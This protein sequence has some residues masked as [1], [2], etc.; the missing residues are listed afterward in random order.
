MHAES[1]GGKEQARVGSVAAFACRWTPAGLK[2]KGAGSVLSKAR[3]T[4]GIP[5]ATIKRVSRAASS[6]AATNGTGPADGSAPEMFSSARGGQQPDAGP[7]ARPASRRALKNWRV[8]SRLF[9]LVIIPTV[10]AVAAGG[11]FIATSV[12]SAL[13]LQRVQTLANLSGKITGLVQALQTE[14][15]DTVRFIVLGG[16]DGGRGALP[17]S[18]PPPGPELSLLA[19][20][21]GISTGWADQVKS[22]AGGVDGSYSAL[23]QQDTQAAVTAIGNLPAIRA[24]ATGTQLPALIVI[25]E[26]ATTI[27]TLLAVESQIAVGSGD[28]ALAGSVRVLGLVSGMKEDASEQ[29]ALL[30]SALSNDLVSLNQVQ[31]GPT[32][33]LAIT[34]AQAQQ[35]GGL[36]EFGTA[37]TA[38]QRQLFNS[39]LSSGN[40]V[41]AQAEEQ[42]AISLASSKSPIATDPT[43]SDASSALSYVVSGMRSVEQQFSDSVISRSASL[44]DGSITSA[45]IFSLAVALLLGIALTATTVVGRSMVRPLRRL[46]NGALEVAEVRLPD[47]VRRMS[48]TD[49]EGVALKVEPIDV[50]SSDE[51]GEVARAFDQVHKEAVRLASNEAA[52]RGNINAMFVNLSRRSQVLVERQIRVITR[53]ER[54]EQDS[55]RL[56]NLFQV[57]HL[58]TRMRRNSEN[59]LVLAGQE[60]SR[61]WSRPVALVDVLRA[62]VSEIEQY[63]RVTLNV[64]PGISVGREAVSDVVHLTAELVENATSFSAADTPVTI[65]AHLLSSGGAL[66]EITDQGVGM[67]PEEMPHANWR[68][69]NPPVVDVAVSRRMGLFVVGRLA[70]RHGIRVRLRPAQSGG[71]VALV[72]LP[73]H[74]I[75]REESSPEPMRPASTASGNRI[76]TTITDRFKPG[77][78]GTGHVTPLREVGRDA[79]AGRD[80][81]TPAPR[82]APLREKLGAADSG[83]QLLAGAGD[84]GRN[85]ESL[86]PP[87]PLPRIGNHLRAAELGTGTGPQVTQPGQGGGDQRNGAVS[88][89]ETGTRFAAETS[90]GGPSTPRRSIPLGEV[91]V[92]PAADGLADNER[93]PIFEAVESYWFRRGRQ[94]PNRFDQASEGWSS[95]ADDGWRAAA[96]VVHAPTSDG[97][98]SAGLPKRL[99]AANLVPGTAAAAAAAGSASKTSPSPAPSRS[100]AQTRDRYASFQHGIRQGRAAAAGGN[101]DSG[102]GTTS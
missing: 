1:P 50:D 60:L 96:E 65:A 98:T 85:G 44:H 12:Q 36:N 48:E 86:A 53:L 27:N 68:L 29:Q 4:R 79:S 13:V 99:P 62:A 72:W 92:P 14:R 18:T 41:Q 55:K 58:A 34:D 16:D 84:H 45:I 43:I 37:A 74:T 22:L 80:G 82:S 33:Q 3:K 17:S 23:A 11:I 94:A 102:E 67:S 20:D 30:T 24:A 75:T 9:L 56:A 51:I 8:R 15:E 73:D 78:S 19:Q 10:T 69:D 95:P 81:I 39:V 90:T 5:G 71:L 57:D 42:Q 49:G 76:V 93:L 6:S 59:L 91:V 21:Y 101:P 32:T 38:E 66:I 40:V 46:R 87:G 63:E 88:A 28:S 61:R 54:S 83:P 7:A 52:L 97:T 70:A 26:Y 100:A 64:Q 35:Q 31:F 25:K 89:A 77:I 2:V 47:T